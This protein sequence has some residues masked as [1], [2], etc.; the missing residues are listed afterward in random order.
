MQSGRKFTQSVKLFK[1]AGIMAA[2]EVFFPDLAVWFILVPVQL[3]HF[4]TYSCLAFRAEKEN[5]E[6]AD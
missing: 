3:S 1:I 4:T 2:G 6:G 5:S